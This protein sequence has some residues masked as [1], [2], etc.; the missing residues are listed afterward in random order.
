MPK[1]NAVLMVVLAFAVIAATGFVVLRSSSA[2]V[3]ESAQAE[4][5]IRKLADGDVDTR[6]EGEDGLRK[7]GPAAVAPLKE[8]SKS[9]DRVLAGR[10][11]KLLGELQ[12]AAVSDRPAPA[13]E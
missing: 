9:P 5:L 8:A 6:R 11:A 12:P 1:L 10:A 2:A 3:D 13:A 7:L 4:K